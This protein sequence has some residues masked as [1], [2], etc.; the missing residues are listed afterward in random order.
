MTERAKEN[1]ASSSRLKA[2]PKESEK[3]GLEAERDP[4]S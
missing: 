1:L 3:E 4:R 2:E